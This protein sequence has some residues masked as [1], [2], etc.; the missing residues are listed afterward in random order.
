MCVGSAQVGRGFSLFSHDC[1]QDCH[2]F[3]NVLGLY[4]NVYSGT[5][6]F[7]RSIESESLFLFKVRF[8]LDLGSS[9]K[10]VHPKV[11]L[12]FSCCLAVV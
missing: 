5:R 7:V 9:N 11:K 1:E 10:L 6:K 2:E 4:K 3:L 12:L 8:T